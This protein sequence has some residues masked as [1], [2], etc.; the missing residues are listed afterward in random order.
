MKKQG[1][2]Y[3]VTVTLEV[4]YWLNDDDVS[5]PKSGIENRVLNVVAHD[6]LDGWIKNREGLVSMDFVPLYYDTNPIIS[7]YADREFDLYR[8]NERL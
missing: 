7:D 5:D 4:N 6:I 2:T 1:Q 8:E 3:R